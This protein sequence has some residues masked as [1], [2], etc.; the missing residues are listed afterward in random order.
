M[1]QKGAKRT[2]N[3]STNLTKVQNKKKEEEEE[4]EEEETIPNRWYIFQKSSRPPQSQSESMREKGRF[5][6][7]QSVNGS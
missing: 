5:H 7:P 1:F 6:D 3:L 4:E 2:T